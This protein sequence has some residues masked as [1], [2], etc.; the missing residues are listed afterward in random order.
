MAIY[1]RYPCPSISCSINKLS[2]HPLY[3][4]LL[5]IDRYY[6]SLFVIDNYP[7]YGGNCF[8]SYYGINTNI[9]DCIIYIKEYETYS[10][11]IHS[12]IFTNC[13][14]NLDRLEFN[15]SES[16]T[17]VNCQ[18]NQILENLPLIDFLSYTEIP[19]I[20]PDIF[21]ASLFY[22]SNWLGVN[23]NEYDLFKT[24]RDVEIG[25]GYFNKY[26][27][28]HLDNFTNVYITLKKSTKNY[29][30]FIDIPINCI[31]K[32]G[33]Y[34]LINN[35]ITCGNLKSKQ[36]EFHQIFEPQSTLECKIRKDNILCSPK[37][38][39]VLFVGYFVER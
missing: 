12:N 32:Q 5:N 17:F 9:L 18:F 21:K 29:P 38:V 24:I 8:P 25:T 39:D 37:L 7:T 22:N 6:K 3:S 20:T 14:F 19:E 16:S 23:Y 30:F 31:S 13:V 28:T 36:I 1:S 26:Q 33:D 34:F 4:Y 15:P 11:E 27:E 10:K 35:N 2:T